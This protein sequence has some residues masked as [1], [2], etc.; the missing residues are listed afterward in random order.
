MHESGNQLVQLH[1]HYV[2][3]LCHVHSVDC[4]CHYLICNLK[5]AVRLFLD[6]GSTTPKCVFPLLLTT[7]VGREVVSEHF[8]PFFRDDAD[9]DVGAFSLRVVSVSCSTAQGTLPDPRSLKIPAEIA[10]D[11]RFIASCRCFVSG[12]RY[13][14]LQ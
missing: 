3:T 2:G 13:L 14:T 6:G 1:Y 9:I 7:F 12:V 5:V 8:R 4:R 11:T 10:A